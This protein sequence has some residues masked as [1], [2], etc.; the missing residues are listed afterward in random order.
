VKITRLLFAS[1][2][3]LTSGW[4]FLYAHTTIKLLYAVLTNEPYYLDVTSFYLLPYALAPF[5]ALSYIDGIKRTSEKLFLVIKQW[6][7]FVLLTSFALLQLVLSI[8]CFYSFFS[9]FTEFKPTL[10]WFL[11]M[12]PIVF[13]V[14]FILLLRFLFQTRQSLNSSLTSNYPLPN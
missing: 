2:V 13:L 10:E 9:T 8:V 11:L 14:I 4:L 1:G 3:F 6:L 7:N 5:S 12:L